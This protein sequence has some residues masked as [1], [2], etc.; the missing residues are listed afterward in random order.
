LIDQKTK[1]ELLLRWCDEQLNF[2]QYVLQLH[3]K[4][5]SLPD[6]VD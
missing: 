5:E 1:N 3:I 2:L 6:Q 4:A